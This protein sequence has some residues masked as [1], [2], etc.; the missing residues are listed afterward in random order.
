[1]NYSELSL[2][3]NLLSNFPFKH[4]GVTLPAKEASEVILLTVKVRR[5]NDELKKIMDGVLAS[6]KSEGFDER[7]SKYQKMTDI[8]N[9]MKAYTDWSEGT[10][11]ERPAK[12]TDAELKEAETNKTETDAFEK[13]LREL[14]E[15]YRMAYNKQLTEEA[16]SFKK[17][18]AETFEKIV[19]HIGF[20]TEL[21]V[22]APA[23]GSVDKIK[24]SSKEYLETFGLIL[25]HAD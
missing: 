5:A 25:V 2:C 20:D 21:G 3:N 1:M 22:N 6:L 24:I 8:E 15:K 18:S 10:D 14:D 9:R 12:P 13:E 16:P 23:M 7:F 19:A 4:R 11:G 17:L